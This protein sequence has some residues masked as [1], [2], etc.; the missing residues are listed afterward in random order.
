MAIPS[1]FGPIILAICTAS[2]GPGEQPP[3]LRNLV[4]TATPAAAGDA[5]SREPETAA[6]RPLSLNELVTEALA[7]NLE[8]RV[9]E[10][11]I[12]EAAALLELARSQAF[13][14]AS[15]TALF[16]G[17]TPEARTTELNNIDTVTPDSLEGDFNFGRLGFTLRVSGQLAQPL[18][19]FGKIDSSKEAAGHL[20]RAA[21]HQR[22]VAQAELVVNVNRAFWAFQL[23]QA[24]LDTIQEGQETLANVL[25]RIE[26]LLDAD[27]TQVTEN[28]RLRLKYALSTLFVRKTEAEQAAETALRAMRLLLGWKQ[29]RPLAV[30]KRDLDDLPDER[31]D[32]Q[33][34][35]LAANF[36]RPELRALRS[37]V[38][39]AE[40]F[41][42]FR[43]AAFYPSLFIGGF[44]D[45]A[46]TS[47]ATD[48]TNPFI[49][50]PFNFL[51]LAAGLGLRIDL[52][53]FTKLAQLEQA[54][55]QTNV[56][57]SQ[58]ELA[59]QA[60]QLEVHTKY[61]EITGGY[62]RIE[63]LE[64][65][66]RTARGWLTA[67]ALAYDIGTGRADELIDAFLAFA[68]SEAELQTT[69]FN[70]LLNLVDFARVTGRLMSA[71][72]R[73]LR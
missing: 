32:L 50:D 61:L 65:A 25:D 27:S 51:T 21:Q 29:D 67:S 36:K 3:G 13:P 72:E 12:G 54:K 10:A 59:T 40:A 48:Q 62:Q 24:F 37:V 8:I 63:A 73:F 5:S 42:E 9:T 70:T 33:S 69:R 39:A 44:L 20:V 43:E 15:L 52:D 71:H 19:T 7:N 38:N 18:Y 55:A 26:A 46:Y 23:T 16:G 66:N 49:Y 57:T 35:L 6:P 56:R 17:P 47:N 11:Q 53:I 22:T 34:A 68:A 45:Y 60:V 31:P 41:V 1:S 58:A 28:D 2:P 30:E 4:A 14:T 64:K